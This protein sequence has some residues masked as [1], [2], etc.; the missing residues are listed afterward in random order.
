[1]L[2]KSFFV[3]TEIQPREVELPDG[4]T[5]TLYFKELPAVE[6]NR[7]FNSIKSTDEDVSLLASAKLVV[8][9]LCEADGS[10]AL[11]LEQAA[12]LKP[13]PLGVILDN[14]RYVNGLGEEQ[15]KNV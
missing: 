7:Y 12:L 1:M 15:P 3:S 13:G 11:T 10:P 4:K 14:L 9:G 2:D 5:H 8:A 6:F